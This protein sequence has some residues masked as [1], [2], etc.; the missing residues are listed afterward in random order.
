MLSVTLEHKTTT[1]GDYN[2]HVLQLNDKVVATNYMNTV[3]E[4]R[5]GTKGVVIG[6]A[7]NSDFPLVEFENGAT[8]VCHPT[9]EVTLLS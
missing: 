8:F 7:E 1:T 2:P 5:E 3:I 4:V 9:H 6:F